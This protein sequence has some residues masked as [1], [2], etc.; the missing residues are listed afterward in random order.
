VRRSTGL[1]IPNLDVKWQLINKNNE[2]HNM[3]ISNESNH[4]Y[5]LTASCPG[6]VGTTARISGFLASRH[7]YITDMQQ[8]DDILSG[9]FFMR[10][11]FLRDEKLSP[12]LDALR[13][14]F[15]KPASEEGMEWAIHDSQARMRVL[16][17][18]SKFDHC[19]NDLLYR[20]SIGELNM[21]VTAVVSNH[22]D[23]QKLADWYNVPYY[24]LPVTAETKPEQEARLK[25]IV[26]E[27]ASDLVVLARY[28][29]VLSDDLCRYLQGRAINI[30]HSFLPGFKGAKPYHQAHS[31]GV[32][33]IGATAHFVTADLDE[34]PIIEQVVERVD[35]T[36]TP[37]KMVSA[38]RNSECVALSRA[39]C[40]YVE[41][42]IFV[43]GNKT[44]VF[45]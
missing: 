40:A 18:V 11:T 22:P 45:R 8:F 20:Q 42:R 44:V 17:M 37:D 28:M 23:L 19:L 16:I 24:H 3:T 41:H 36:Y 6:I 43:N 30:H 5:V 31:R 9:C 25:K 26:E 12:T 15:I 34:G 10:C 33:L 27:T 4:P 7:C 13:Q 2:K 14:E 1:L 32:K 39:V 29:Q 35:H 21:D 38:G